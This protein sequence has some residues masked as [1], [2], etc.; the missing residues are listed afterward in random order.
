MY[1]C[2]MTRVRGS[3]GVVQI[4]F[5]WVG[6]VVDMGVGVKESWRNVEESED[7]DEI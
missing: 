2:Q 3:G 7:E 5:D 1:A 6:T 4:W